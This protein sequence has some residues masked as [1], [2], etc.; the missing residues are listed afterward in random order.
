MSGDVLLN[1]GLEEPKSDDGGL[2]LMDLHMGDD[3]AA[4]GGSCAPLLATE[5]HNTEVLCEE[6]V[7]GH[8]A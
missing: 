7:R 3:A 2:G 4:A 6:R 1:E 8:W 5:A